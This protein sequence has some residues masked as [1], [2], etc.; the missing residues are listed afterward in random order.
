MNSSI[1][2]VLNVRNEENN[3]VDC[4]ASA[5]GFVDEIIVAD[6]QSTDKTVSLAKKAG[7]K[8]I[9]VKNFGYVEPVRNEAIDKAKGPW[10][11]LL[12]A[13]ERMRPS[14][15]KKLRNIARK[16]VSDV[17]EIP[18]QNILFK[19]WIKHTAWWPDYH[20]RFFKKGFVKWSKVVHGSPTIMGKVQ[21]LEAAEKNS[22]IHF[23]ITSVKQMLEK[24][25]R[26]TDVSNNMHMKNNISL[27]YLIAYSEGEFR[28]RFIESHGYKD[29]LHGYL[30]SKFMEFYRFMEIVKAWEKNGYHTKLKEKNAKKQIE[31]SNPLYGR[32]EK[33]E[34]DL[35]KI[36]NAKFYKMWQ[37]YCHFR[38]KL[39]GVKDE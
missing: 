21:R 32:V 29:G 23:N 31:L 25:N 1:S 17:V 27:A 39:L 9:S 37:S 33:L 8:I 4:I 34:K 38:N 16:N 13:D 26:Y 35:A 36:Q 19:K 7:A 12:D 14:L 28:F 24:M 22:V 6:M 15:G 10:I 3:I 18:Y 30:L 2:L 11:L 5:R 20:P